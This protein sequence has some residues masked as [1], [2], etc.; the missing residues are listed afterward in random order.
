MLLIDLDAAGVID[1]A[2]GNGT[3]TR[4]CQAD[5]TLCKVT[6]QRYNMIVGAMRIQQK[7]V[8]PDDMCS[9]PGNSKRDGDVCY[10]Y[11]FPEN[12][13]KDSFV[14]ASTSTT[15]SFNP[16]VTTLSLVLE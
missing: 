10:G 14:G 5:D 8:T 12:E 11:L 2:F 16:E 4:E 1:T 9:I 7:R 15:Y 6:I 13:S 3:G